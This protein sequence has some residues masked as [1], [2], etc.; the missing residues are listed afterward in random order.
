MLAS[1][2]RALRLVHDNRPDHLLLPHTRNRR[3][4]AAKRQQGLCPWGCGTAD[5]GRGDDWSEVL[6]GIDDHRFRATSPQHYTVV[7]VCVA[8]L[9]RASLSQSIH[10]W[11]AGTVVAK[12]AVAQGGIDTP[13]MELHQ[14]S[15]AYLTTLQV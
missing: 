12:L 6:H 7:A 15:F 11:L 2:R 14:V 5:S 1:T 3:M 10:G 9:S 8:H 13:N 4:S